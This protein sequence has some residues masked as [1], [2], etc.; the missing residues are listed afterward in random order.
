[1]EMFAGSTIVLFFLFQFSKVLF[2]T[3][4]LILVCWNIRG[5]TKPWIF[6]TF[7]VVICGILITELPVLVWGVFRFLGKVSPEGHV[8][9]TGLTSLNP[10]FYFLLFLA[11]LGMSREIKAKHSF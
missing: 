4:L 11:L 2:L 7:L 3:V 1:M 9:L 8:W 5:R 6:Y 10:L